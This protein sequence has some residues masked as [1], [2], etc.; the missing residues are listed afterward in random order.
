[1]VIGVLGFVVSLEPPSDEE[2]EGEAGIEICGT[3]GVGSGGCGCSVGGLVV[4]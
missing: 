3:G 1:V 2:T 4:E